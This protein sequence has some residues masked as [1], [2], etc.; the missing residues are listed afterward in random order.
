MPRPTVV[1]V[2]PAY[3][4]ARTLER[5]VRE[6]PEGA[7]DALLLV[8]DA[9]VDETVEVAARLGIPTRV[10]AVNRGYGANQKTC[11]QAALE[12]GADIVVM[13]HPDY[14]Y[15]PTRIPDLVELLRS[16]GY[17]LVL[18]SRMLDGGAKSGGMPW[19]K[20]VANRVLT[21]VQNRLFGKRL[22]EYHTGYRAFSREALELSGF[23]RF[24]EGFAFDAQMIGAMVYR[25]SEIGECASPARYLADSSSVGI[26]ASIRYGLACL[27]V[28]SRFRLNRLGLFP[29]GW[30]AGDAP[31][32]TE[33]HAPWSL[34]MMLASAFALSRLSALDWRFP[35]RLYDSMTYNFPSLDLV[36]L[37]GRAPRTWPIPLLYSL[38]RTDGQR[39]VVQLA[40]GA[41]A[42][43]ALAVAVGRTVRHRTLATA[44]ALAIFTLGLSA[45]VVSWDGL[46]MPESLGITLSVGLTAS[47]VW[48]WGRA[49]KAAAIIGGVIAGLLAISRPG[50]A[51]VVGLIGLC[52]L[53]RA[54]RRG[55]KAEV[56]ATLLILSSIIWLVICLPRQGRAYWNFENEVHGAVSAPYDSDAFAS[57]L[58]GRLLDDPST[59]RWLDAHGAPPLEPG[60]GRPGFLDDRWP[61]GRF[62]AAYGQSELWDAW[63][64]SQGGLLVLVR[65]AI[66]E[67]AAHLRSFAGALP[68]I[69]AS[70]WGSPWYPEYG[71][72][73][74]PPPLARLWFGGVV[75]L[76]VLV[77]VIGATF[78]FRRRLG[79]WRS[80]L[81]RV[82]LAA[83][84]LSG[85]A[86]ATAW[87]VV[88]IELVRHTVPGPVGLRVGLLL[89]AAGVL[90]R[91]LDRSG[92]A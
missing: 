15:D 84:F 82:G 79:A 50:M 54:I 88:G 52:I 38:V 48:L 22:S 30:L 59:A 26:G 36:D 34:L 90:D 27:G 20:R 33:E 60:M 72:S 19:W 76:A 71:A 2:L 39:L 66:D 1:V 58:Y 5:T 29:A 44:I 25:G 16:G 6:I 12:M 53:I 43:S 56:A 41:A 57:V 47:L 92:H 86:I 85:L 24:S 67:P 35:I 45:P 9:S 55:S 62:R 40:L 69:L 65:M 87:L 64:R 78:V 81:F 14:Q 49:S 80:P 21:A 46:I 11:Y 31:R 4:A 83:V 17:G 3:N 13:L 18:G 61:W 70:S 28:A 37:A 10:H 63:F 68:L 42:W 8:D 23:E 77:G 7:A 32:P 75:D 91:A 89:T 74:V 73:T 51:P